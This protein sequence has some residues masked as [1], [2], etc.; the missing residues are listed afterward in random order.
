MRGVFH[1]SPAFG[2]RIGQPA[3]KLRLVVYSLCDRC[4]EAA[5]SRE[6]VEGRIVRE[7]GVM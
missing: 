6:R 1:P 2:K 4:H 5:G 3:G 7:L